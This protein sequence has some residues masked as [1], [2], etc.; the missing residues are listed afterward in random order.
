MLHVLLTFV[1]G[2][3]TVLAPCV[4][5]MLPVI[6]GGSVQ[7]PN[8]YRPYVV[9]ASLVLSLA[10]FTFLLKASTVLLGVD[11][12]VWQVISGGVVLLLGLTMLFPGPWEALVAR[13][14]VQAHTGK[15]LGGAV[16]KN[17]HFVSAVLTGIALGPVFS[18]CSP[19]YA[20]VLSSVLP[21]NTAEG[22]LY[23]FVYCAG[24]AL[25]LLLV[26][27]VGQKFIKKMKWAAN[28]RGAFQRVIAVLFILV[29]VFVMTGF[30][31]KVQTWFVERDVLRLIEL[32]T[33]IVPEN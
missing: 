12:M 26:A 17:N 18:S 24:L 19:T 23:V 30:D 28:P 11:P 14:N 6:V 27:L 21:R 20:W 15:A 3:L 2:F 7:S 25:A 13:F 10:A 5:P 16:Q 33:S 32:E 9:T 22:V 29:G 8:K 4:L 1:A 31:K